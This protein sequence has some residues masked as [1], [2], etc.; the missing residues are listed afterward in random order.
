VSRGVYSDDAALK[1]ERGTGR[2][3]KDDNR[4]RGS[5]VEKYR[6]ETEKVKDSNELRNF[7]DQKSHH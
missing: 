7:E 4:P 6:D 1:W 2:G 5:K 3:G